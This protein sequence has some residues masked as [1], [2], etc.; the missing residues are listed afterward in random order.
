M[1]AFWS[2]LG[3]GSVAMAVVWY[4][5]VGQTC[6]WAIMACVAGVKIVIKAS[7]KTGFDD[8]KENE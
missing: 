5:H 8:G 2:C 6:F 1:F 4:P 3:V 7:S